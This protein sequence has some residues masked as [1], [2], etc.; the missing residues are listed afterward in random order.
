M[1]APP[2][3]CEWHSLNNDTHP[4]RG[5]WAERKISA[6]GRVL[7]IDIAS[8][9]LQFCYSDGV[10]IGSRKNILEARA[11]CERGKKEAYVA[12]ETPVL[13]TEQQYKELKIKPI[14][15]WEEIDKSNVHAAPIEGESAHA[16]IRRLDE[17]TYVV[18]RDSKY[19]GGEATLKDAKMRAEINRVSE[20]NRIMRLWEQTHPE[21]LPPFLLLTETERA[22]HWRRNP[23]R[24][25]VK[26]SLTGKTG[27]APSEDPTSKR[28]REA[29][30]GRAPKP[31]KA[32]K[33]DSLDPSASLTVVNAANPKKAG[34]AAHGRWALLLEGGHATVQAFLD[35]K[36]N[37]ETL[38]NAVAK[39]YVKLG[40]ADASQSEG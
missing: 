5:W 15:K 31:A 30:A 3:P 40:G 18:Y 6:E 12:D 22:E 39:G 20:R 1:P 17:T 2:T 8:P 11:L 10:Y 24:A 29:T 13:T 25:K 4:G 33:P 35:A 9:V 38:K 23:P 28:I 19:L 7:W 34:S 27:G 26:P 14:L 21:E 16:R 37:P 32:P 36:G